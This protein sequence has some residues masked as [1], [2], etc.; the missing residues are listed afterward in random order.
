MKNKGK[1]MKELHYLFEK[2][3]HNLDQ[4]TGRVLF[5]GDIHGHYSDFMRE[6]E[7][8]KFEPNKDVVYSLGDLTDR[9][10]ENLQC[11]ELINEDWFKAMLGNHDLFMLL[12]LIT[13]ENEGSLPGRMWFSP[14]TGGA[15]FKDLNSVQKDR[16]RELAQILSLK[17]SARQV[18][19]HHSNGLTR[20]GLVH[21]EVPNNDWNFVLN[22]KKLENHADVVTES[23]KKIKSFVHDRVKV[24]DI[25]HV[26]NIDILISGHSI[27]NKPLWLH[28]HLYIDT[29][30]YKPDGYISVLDQ[31]EIRLSKKMYNIS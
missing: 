24:H 27:V 29:G 19:I 2:T 13:G 8:L 15:W 5:A 18:D 3:T 22:K 21:A 4:S 30:S 1:I 12:F 6:L 17:P 23:R 20:F 9:G 14:R 28:N 26:K 31:E 7:K 25:P 16:V 10:K 11:L